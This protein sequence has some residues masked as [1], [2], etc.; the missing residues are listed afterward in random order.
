M[1][2]E[3]TAPPEALPRRFLDAILT[4]GTELSLPAVL[5]HIVEAACQL[6]DARYGALGV[7][8]TDG[9][10]SEFVHHGVDPDTVEAIGTLPEGR[11][12]LGT[13]ITDPKPLRL[14]DVGEHPD[15]YG[16][17]ANHPPMR[18]FL[19]VPIA[20]RG[21]AVFGNL[22][23]AE[24][25]DGRDFTDEDEEMVVGL[26]AAASVTIEN[27]R[28]LEESRQRE[29]RLEAL[30]AIAST[31]LEGVDAQTVLEVAAHHARRLAGADLVGIVFPRER[32]HAASATLVVE[33]ADGGAAERCRGLEMPTDR[34]FAG[35]AI[36]T[37]EPVV[38][39]DAASDARGAHP[40]VEES[41]LGPLI[42]VPM[43]VR[44]QPIGALVTANER[45][46]REFTE[47]D[48]EIMQTFSDQ[49]AVV[50]EYAR[51]ERELERLAVME[52]RERIARDLHDTVIQQLFATG[53]MLQSVEATVGDE[54]TS[55][56]I[57][58]AVENLDRT[59]R[60]IRSAIFALQA[61]GRSGGG[62]RVDVLKLANDASASLGFE[63][64][65]HF[66]GRID[67]LPEELAADLLATLRE[68]LA[69]V[70]KHAGAKAVEV[71]LET[72]TEVTLSV[73]DDGRGVPADISDHAEGHGLRNMRARAER[74]DGR[75]T[76]GPAAGGG[77]RV[78]WVAPLPLPRSR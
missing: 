63:P 76:I 77:T 60:D 51:V 29:R 64:R 72:D 10:L 40:F 50:V 21:G 75:F 16:F 26:A 74:R 47:T 35:T 54:G 14:R 23:L 55:Q 34:S 2:R 19:G 66:A 46:G 62:L 70:A 1:D 71:R 65:V 8:G 22:Y 41:G 67:T 53:M 44:G 78:E 30:R 52:D 20:G 49:A 32:E 6:L 9:R 18:T 59:I 42:A 57:G 43:R 33:V 12:V 27:A 73:T 69:N 36:A 58:Q 38:T 24:K 37:A 11:G 61:H 3:V 48:V 28:L 17:P 5:R 25:R 68:S 13:L 31:M 45:G 39:V 4:I 56:R 7:I 15:S